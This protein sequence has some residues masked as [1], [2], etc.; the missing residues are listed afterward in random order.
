M[1]P[2]LEWT[3]FPVNHPVGRA[4]PKSVW[5]NASSRTFGSGRSRRHR[6]GPGQRHRA[7]SA[8]AQCISACSPP[9]KPPGEHADRAAPFYV[10]NALLTLSPKSR[11]VLLRTRTALMQCQHLG[12]SARCTIR[13][14]M[15]ANPSKRPATSRGR[16]RSHN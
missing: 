8:P 9:L 16:S 13:Y 3:T 7:A 5:L 6:Y 2:S 10:T 12:L 11:S 1:M 4:N 15:C 14:P